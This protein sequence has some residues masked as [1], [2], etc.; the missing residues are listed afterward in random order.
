MQGELTKVAVI[1]TQER[2]VASGLA[3]RTHLDTAFGLVVSV[4]R[5]AGEHALQVGSVG[6]V[7]IRTYLHAAHG[8]VVSEQTC[9]AERYAHASGEVDPHVFVGGA[10]LDAVEVRGGVG[11]VD[12]EIGRGALV[13]TEVG[14]VEGK[15]AVGAGGAAGV[16]LGGEVVHG[17]FGALQGAA[18]ADRIGDG[19]V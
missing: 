15:A 10:V 13:D 9:G 1:L 17:L 4:E 5:S 14:L 3:G 2:V 12:S 19:R 16:G 6:V 18:A 8:H 11:G 7:V